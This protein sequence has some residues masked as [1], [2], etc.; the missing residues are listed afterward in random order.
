[1]S[2]RFIEYSVTA[3]FSRATNYLLTINDAYIENALVCTK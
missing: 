2:M 1:M 3:R